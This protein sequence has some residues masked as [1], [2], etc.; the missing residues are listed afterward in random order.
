[1]STQ[2]R[3]VGD[4]DLKRLQEARD[5]GGTTLEELASQLAE[6]L[7]NTAEAYRALRKAVKRLVEDMRP[8]KN[9]EERDPMYREA[10]RR[11]DEALSIEF[12]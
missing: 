4:S 12:R 8:L 10:I 5:A 3:V 9:V 7:I 2:K 1:M 6:P 11:L